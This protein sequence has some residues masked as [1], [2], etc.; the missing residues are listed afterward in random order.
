MSSNRRSP[1]FKRRLE[2]AID[3]AKAAGATRVKLN[4]DGSCEI[5][6]RPDAEMGEINDFDRPPNPLG[7]TKRR[8]SSI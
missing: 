6:F 4:P 5:D 7:T 8:N 3:A 2:A 1:P